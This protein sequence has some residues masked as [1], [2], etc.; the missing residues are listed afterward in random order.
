MVKAVACKRLAW[1]QEMGNRAVFS[2]RLAKW[3]K[4]RDW[5]KRTLD[6]GSELCMSTKTRIT[7]VK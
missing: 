1:E 3:L 6:H 4:I 2:H 7:L 5:H